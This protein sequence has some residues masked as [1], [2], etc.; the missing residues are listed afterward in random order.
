MVVFHWFVGCGLHEDPDT[1]IPG[2]LLQ[3]SVR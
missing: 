1:E 2:D 3:V